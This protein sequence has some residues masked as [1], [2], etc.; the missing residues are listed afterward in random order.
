MSVLYGGHNVK[1]DNEKVVTVRKLELV[2]A[3][4]KEEWKDITK[5]CE[6]KPDKMSLSD[7]YVIDIYYNGVNI[8]VLMGEDQ[9]A[10][11]IGGCTN[12]YKTEIKDMP[13]S[14]FKILKRCE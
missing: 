3:K 10:Y 9:R 1:L 8:G 6:F 11:T 13:N 2:K 7:D 12:K 4:P 5:G 14:H